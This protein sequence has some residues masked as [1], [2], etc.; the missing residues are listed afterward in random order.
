L[1]GDL[2]A[3][4]EN[5]NQGATIGFFEGTSMVN[6][7]LGRIKQVQRSYSKPRPSEHAIQQFI[8]KFSQKLKDIPESN[9]EVVVQRVHSYPQ[10][11]SV[12]QAKQACKKNL[13]EISDFV[14]TLHPEISSGKS[15]FQSLNSNAPKRL[16]V[17]RLQGGSPAI[18]RNQVV[19]PSAFAPQKSSE[20]PRNPKATPEPEHKLRSDKFDFTL[21]IVDDRIVVTLIPSRAVESFT[22]NELI[23]CTLEIFFRFYRKN[24]L[25]DERMSNRFKEIVG[26]D[27]LN[28]KELIRRLFFIPGTDTLNPNLSPLP[29]K[30][31]IQ[32]FCLAEQKKFQ[33]RSTA[34][35]QPIN[36]G[37]KKTS[38]ILDS[39][40]SMNRTN[41]LRNSRMR[42][43]DIS[44]MISVKP[45]NEE[46]DTHTLRLFGHSVL[47]LESLKVLYFVHTQLLE[48]D[49]G[50]KFKG[51]SRILG[52]KESIALSVK[53]LGKQRK[54][55]TTFLNEIQKIQVQK[56]YQKFEM[57]S[58]KQERPLLEFSLKNVLERWN[59]QGHK[60]ADFYLKNRDLLSAKFNEIQK[61]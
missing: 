59:H 10:F 53:D 1:G 28:A 12:C 48:W 14:R 2:K 6:N 15:V 26:F 35:N 43:N 57:P 5:S 42:R 30:Q 37:T 41:S 31:E 60:Y 27:S 51:I 21:A 22:Y 50:E 16:P 45:R 33:R 32:G 7:P 56:L 9:Q 20:P 58:L 39:K 52:I 23:E 18:Q 24:S 19:P 54:N 11:N 47:F 36:L 17:P 13:R 34:A 49:F 4:M 25:E 29:W 8:F 61:N 3:A 44:R 46:E 55:L 40:A 38:S